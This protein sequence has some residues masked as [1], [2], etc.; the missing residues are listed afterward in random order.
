MECKCC[1]ATIPNEAKYCHLCGKQ[2][3]S[4]TK[5]HRRHR[6]QSQGTITKLSGQRA[7]PYWVR[8]PADYSSGVPTRE[9][10]GCFP[11]Y[12]SAAAALAKAL[13]A[14]EQA[15]QQPKTLTLQDI[16]ERFIRSHYYEGLSKHAQ[17][18]HRSAWRHLEQC[19]KV[20]VSAINKDTFQK[21]ID[22]MCHAGFKRET[23][24]KVRNLA[25]LLCKEAMGLSL[26][27]T[28]YGALVQLP[29]TDTEPAKP[30]SSAQINLLW[31]A[32]D[33]G[34]KDAMTVLVLIYTGMRPGELLST[35]IAQHLHTKGHFCY[36]QHGSKSAAGRNRIIPI[37]KILHPIIEQL[38]DGRTS[39]PLIAAEQGGFWRV[40]NW[41]SR[42]FRPLMSRLS[43]QG[44]TPYSCRHTF[45]NILKRRGV[46]PL[47]AKE[48]FG[49]ADYATTV[50]RYQSTTEE[51]ITQICVAIDD[52][53]RP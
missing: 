23:M 51:D 18:S 28:N 47:I 22:A 36:I 15:E 41:R 39:G 31:K 21:P 10:L 42:R 9:S 3:I 12:A 43:L 13:Y 48:V 40:D 38:V 14:P 11:S 6:P 33:V 7:N 25:S 35:D 46:D 19:A 49:H 52:I 29:R 4:K 20:P 34:D 16:Y 26:M 2:Q 27:T 45:A 37:P 1:H 5:R 32:S 30:F 44:F 50:E 8:L 17:G 53:D 24:A